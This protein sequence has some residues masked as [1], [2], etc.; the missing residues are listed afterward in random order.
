M[1]HGVAE[2]QRGRETEKWPSAFFCSSSRSAV[3]SLA[4]QMVKQS[5]NPPCHR[6][7]GV[8]RGTSEATYRQA[9][10]RGSGNSRSSNNNNRQ[11]EE[12]AN[13][14]RFIIIIISKCCS[15]VG[16]FMLQYCMLI[17]GMM[18]LKGIN[19]KKICVCIY[20]L[21]RYG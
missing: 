12:A 13:G 17:K 16:E 10:Q 18:D 14:A 9:T 15:I 19:I 3:H 7:G 4:E 5:N 6:Q 2:G 11:G 1:G 20:V 8:G 21:V